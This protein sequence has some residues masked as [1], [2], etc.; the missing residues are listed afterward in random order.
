MYPVT[1]V[2]HNLQKIQEVSS[3]CSSS[4][5]TRASAAS[6]GGVRRNRG[7][8]TRR[9]VWAPEL[10]SIGEAADRARMEGRI[11]GDRQRRR[12]EDQVRG[13][14]QTESI[15]RF[16]PSRQPGKYY[17]NGYHVCVYY[18]CILRTYIPA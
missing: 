11:L 1:P 2:E 6:L 12:L 18:S 8:W 9:G 17:Q 3:E 15:S 7:V 10:G 4:A 14:A 5:G 13:H 16:T